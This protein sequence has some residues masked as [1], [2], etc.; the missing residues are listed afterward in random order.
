MS[1]HFLCPWVLYTCSVSGQNARNQHPR[2][3]KKKKRQKKRS[4]QMATLR[5]KCPPH[6]PPRASPIVSQCQSA[7]RPRLH[8]CLRVPDRRR[9]MF[10]LRGPRRRRASKPRRMS[11]NQPLSLQIVRAPRPCQKDVPAAAVAGIRGYTLSRL[12]YV[13]HQSAP[14]STPRAR[15]ASATN[16][17]ALG[18]CHVYAGLLPLVNLD[19]KRKAGRGCLLHSSWY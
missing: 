12:I 15:P 13:P 5:S 4:S 11:R 17:W 8:A 6:A 7:K 19:P 2:P 16:P 18:Y 14:E 1:H 3:D 10:D 9:P